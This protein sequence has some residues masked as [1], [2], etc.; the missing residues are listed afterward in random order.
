MF[1]KKKLS[2][3]LVPMCLMSM[4]AGPELSLADSSGLQPMKTTDIFTSQTSL[5]T[6]E[7]SSYDAI[8]PKTVGATYV[9]DAQGNKVF[10][11]DDTPYS[12]AIKVNDPDKFKEDYSLIN[13]YQKNTDSNPE[14]PIGV[15]DYIDDSDC[16]NLVKKIGL[17][18]G[19]VCKINFLYSGIK[20]TEDNT[21]FITFEFNKL[22]S[23]N[24]PILNK[25]GQ[26]LNS[27]LLKI[28]GPSILHSQPKLSTTY[29]AIVPNAELP[30]TFKLMNIGTEEVMGAPEGTIVPYAGKQYP[31]FFENVYYYLSKYTSVTDKPLGVNKL[32][33]FPIY[34]TKNPKPGLVE[35]RYDKGKK[36]QIQ[37]MLIS[38]GFIE[39]I[40]Y[41]LNFK[42]GDRSS[43]PIK[44]DP[45]SMSNS[46]VSWGSLVS[47]LPEFKNF[48]L[49]LV[50]TEGFAPAL[51]MNSFKN[52]LYSYS[53]GK[54]RDYNGRYFDDSD[55]LKS[56]K[57]DWDKTCFENPFASSVSLAPTD[58]SNI[59]CYLH[60]DS[61][62]LLSSSFE[63]KKPLTFYLMASYN[64]DFEVEGGYKQIVAIIQFNPGYD[65]PNYE[66]SKE[67]EDIKYENGT[68]FA[69]H[70]GYQSAINWP[71]CQKFSDDAFITSVNN[72]LTCVSKSKA[73]NIIP[74]ENVK[75]RCNS[76]AVG[77]TG[78][79]NS[80]SPSYY[81][82]GCSGYDALR[83]PI[84]YD[85]IM[86]NL[87]W[88]SEAS[89][90]AIDI[91]DVKTETYGGS[92]KFS[93]ICKAG[94]PG[95][96]SSFFNTTYNKCHTE[97]Q[98][99]SFIGGYTTNVVCDNIS[100]NSVSWDICK[101]HGGTAIDVVDEKLQC[102][103]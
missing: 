18:Q 68:L 73:S 21:S 45:V 93:M 58:P 76:F 62:Q 72:K 31:L 39:P 14:N 69:R 22:G 77:Y 87:N 46:E 70:G 30:N 102:S 59:K 11:K 98:G 100:N 16:Q 25:S 13:I 1:Y 32:A 97:P 26:S 23:V 37:K 57:L 89:K 92:D 42:L 49:Y 79:G 86:N 71:E 65:T 83:H 94:V 48:K 78:T 95:N 84:N 3:L 43:I 51:S 7:G 34:F 6:I 9:L 29:N 74:P 75:E 27:S 81:A 44:I 24:V 64:A 53:G 67:W 36:M 56:I 12:I 50:P 66:L 15:L 5:Q 90:E 85:I 101:L 35:F 91:I 40:D 82:Y 60:L 96:W 8:A 28:K 103:K 88:C 33:S 41:V 38:S 17:L 63:N 19:D 4:L 20:P 54:Y 47:Y 2:S 80:S 52:N 99:R 10:E 55:I 61:S